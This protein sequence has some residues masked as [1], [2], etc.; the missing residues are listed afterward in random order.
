[1]RFT[2]PNC[3]RF[4]GIQACEP[5]KRC[6]ECN[7]DYPIGTKILVI[8]LGSL[9]DV[10]V[11]TS[12]LKA[13]K[14]THPQSTV[15]WLTSE[16]AATLLQ[17][18]PFIDR[19]LIWN[20]ETRLILSAM[21]FDVVINADKNQLAAA[22]MMQVQAGRKLGFSINEHGA[23]VPVNH[24]ANYSYYVG[25]DDRYRFKHNKKTQQQMLAETFELPFIH[26]PYRIELSDE[27]LDFCDTWYEQY[28]IHENDVTIGI[29]TGCPPEWPQRKL[30]V[31]KQ[32]KL[33]NRI[34]ADLPDAKILLLGDEPD[35]GQ[36][37]E[38]AEKCDG[39]VINTPT[40]MGLR[41]RLCFI[42]LAD[43]VVTGD[44][45][46][47]HAAIGLRK[48]VI[49]WFGMGCPQETDLFDRGKKIITD[50]HCAP[51]RD[52]DC[53]DH[54]CVERMDVNLIFHHVQDAYMGM[55]S[56]EIER[57]VE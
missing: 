16:S 45:F 26:E 6:W 31:D 42:D 47:M 18:N 23:I 46:G 39:T 1:M 37:Q 8:N 34:H 3:R 25:L 12:Q 55:K 19:V 24:G 11:T 44:T 4:D 10:L 21:Q 13:L 48:W 43:I 22:Y 49:V 7:D 56:G 20:E 27:E 57:T 40:T 53:N 15:F 14:L 36:N 38:L 29:N 50:V 32:V 35:T 28:E 52:V 9:S 33:I 51:C 2:I 54:I 30:T 5:D 17:S 41:Q